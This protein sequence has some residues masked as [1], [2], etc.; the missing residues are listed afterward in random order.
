MRRLG[1]ALLTILFPHHCFLCGEVI[2]PRQ[3]LCPD[4]ARTAAYVLPPLCEHCGRN[5][6]DCTCR[7][8]SRSF[9]RSVSPFYHK[10]VVKKGIQSLKMDNYT[11][12]VDGFA[13]EMAEVVRREYGGIAF[14]CVTAVPMHRRDFR[15]R[16]FDQTARLAQALSER[17][18]VPYIPTLT[19]LQYTDPQKE[20]TAIRRQGNLLGVFDVV[21]DVA[22]QTVL[23]VDDVTTT[24]STLEECAKMLK[25]FGA[26]AVY[27]V[28]AAAALLQR[29]EE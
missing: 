9:E 17:L 11:T 19:K 26:E 25:I 4:C 20:L 22:G 27:A 5:E 1:K 15:Q 13:D 14:H 29:Q 28:T 18:G 24:G 8:H 6:D 2:L 16:G 23:L 3:K 7:G 10:G 12:V 21:A